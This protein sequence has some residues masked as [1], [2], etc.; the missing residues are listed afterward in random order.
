MDTGYGIATKFRCEIENACKIG[1]FMQTDKG[2]EV[3]AL[4]GITFYYGKKIIDYVSEIGNSRPSE[5]P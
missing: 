3:V 1:P 4:P 2:N 5:S